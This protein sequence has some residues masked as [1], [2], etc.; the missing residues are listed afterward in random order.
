VNRISSLIRGEKWGITVVMIALLLPHTSFASGFRISNHGAKATAM[1]NAFTATADNPSAIAYNPAGLTNSKGTNIYLG[2]T[3]VIPSITYRSPTGI[4]EDTEDQVFFPFHF[5]ISSDFGMEN[6]VFGI[7]IFSPFGI[8]TKW[9]KEGLV[10]FNATES[11][12]DTV[13]I[14][15]TVAYQLL[16]TLS[17][18]VGI[19]YMFSKALLKNMVDQSLFGAGD[20]ELT[21]EGDG[22]GWGFNIGALFTPNKKLSLGLTYRNRIKVDINGTA[23]LKNIAPALQPLFGGPRFKTD[24]SSSIEFPDVLS[25]GIAYRPTESLT[26]E[27]D[28]EWTGW[29]SYDRLDIDLEDE[30]PLAGF[31]DSS[32]DK[33][34]KDVGAI[35]VGIEYIATERFSL[36][37]GYVFDKSPAPE[38]TLH[39]RLPDSDQHNISLGLGYRRKNFN[40]DIV[41]IAAIYEDR[42]VD[43][44]ILSGEYETFAHLIGYSFG[45]RF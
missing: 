28:I 3:A 33:N 8:G 7:G 24:A 14:N 1:G 27:L 38:H 35:K 40:I 23:K 21:L 13:L 29:S 31:V 26:L 16:P 5:Y 17:I 10:R 6:L 32:E 20:G 34:W 11:K 19:D 37:A 15:P 43:N 45:Y 30:I 42:T 4:S 18:G 12:L 41:Y 9:D 44:T 25:A 2:A 39:P 36:R 22:D